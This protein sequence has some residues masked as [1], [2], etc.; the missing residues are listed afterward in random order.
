MRMHAYHTHVK[1]CFL[2]TH[3]HTPF[4]LLQIPHG[5]EKILFSPLLIKTYFL[6]LAQKI[7]QTSRNLEYRIFV[8][9]FSSTPA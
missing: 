6:L 9:I 2:N 4:Q 1:E 3:A 7:F 8:L 5:K